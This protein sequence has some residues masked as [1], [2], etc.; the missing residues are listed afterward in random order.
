MKIL[1]S[2]I[3]QSVKDDIQGLSTNT[4]HLNKR[5][6][7][8]L[9]KII[10]RLIQADLESQLKLSTPGIDDTDV[11]GRTALA[12]TASRGDDEAVKVLLNHHADPNI[13]R[14]KCISPLQ[15]ACQTNTMSY[16][17]PLIDVGATTNHANV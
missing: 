16:I 2:T 6:L 17:K 4:A 5:Q 9:H 8:P 13:E 15:C 12:W 3:D 10:L 7:P 1:G 11:D 14:Q